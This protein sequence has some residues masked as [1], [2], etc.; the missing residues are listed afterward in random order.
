MFSSPTRASALSNRAS[1]LT[2]SARIGLRLCGMALLPCWPAPNGSN[3]SA[4]SV[5]CRCRTSTLIR[6]SVPPRM[7]SV[8][9]SSAWRSRLT[10][11]VGGRVRR[12]AQR[13][14][15]VA[16][17]LGADV[18][19]AADGAGDLADRDPLRRPLQ[20]LR[21]ALQLREPAGRLEAESDG[22][23]VDPVAA[24][25]H[26]GRP[27]LQRQPPDDLHQA[28]Q[29]VPPRRPSRPAGSRR[30]RCPARR[31]WSARSAASDPP[32]PAA[33]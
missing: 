19:V 28:R 31:S 15:D 4:T 18:G 27:M 10:T 2:R 13:L 21:V 8:V 33:R 32:A 14:A 5:R 24:A 25:D 16:L 20:P 1:P 6:S 29:L 3:A 22:L 26:R 7:A 12:Q 30:W 23:G 11:W 9:S 17:N